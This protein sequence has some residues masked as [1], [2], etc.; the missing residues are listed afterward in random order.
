MAEVNSEGNTIWINGPTI[1]HRWKTSAFWE[2]YLNLAEA[3]G[4][5]MSSHI[6]IMH[7]CLFYW[8]LKAWYISCDISLNTHWLF[9]YYQIISGYKFNSEKEKLIDIELYSFCDFI[10][11]Y[12]LA[13]IWLN[14]WILWQKL[15]DFICVNLFRFWPHPNLL[16]DCSWLYT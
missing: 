5:H 4:S 3:P 7:S 8:F 9:Q 2:G 6:Q 13:S 1:S 16:R 11:Y 15:L 10:L 12:I 14:K